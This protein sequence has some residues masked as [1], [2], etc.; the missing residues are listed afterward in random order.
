MANLDSGEIS[1]DTPTVSS[2]SFSTDTSL[3]IR[4]NPKTYIVSTLIN[5]LTVILKPLFSRPT[6][7]FSSAF[8]VQAY[9]NVPVYTEDDVHA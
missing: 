5:L 3:P 1:Y 7:F 6:R 9:P 8:L 2:I 4:E